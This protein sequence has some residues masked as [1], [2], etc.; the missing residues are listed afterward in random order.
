MTGDT[1]NKERLGFPLRHRPAGF[2]AEYDGLEDLR[3]TRTVDTAIH[4][5]PGLPGRVGGKLQEQVLSVAAWHGSES[6]SHL[7]VFN[8]L[9]S[10]RL[11]ETNYEPS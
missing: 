5:A 1:L 7:H 9:L 2:A 4:L 8:K 10:L 11:R 6:Q 3:C